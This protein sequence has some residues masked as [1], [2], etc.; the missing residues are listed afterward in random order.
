MGF[1]SFLSFLFD[2]A[3]KPAQSSTTAS[4]GAADGA[5]SGDFPVADPKDNALSASP[6]PPN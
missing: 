6:R 3:P 1:L 4:A 5:G 2:D